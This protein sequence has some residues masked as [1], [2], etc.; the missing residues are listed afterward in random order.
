VHILELSW[1]SKYFNEDGLENVSFLDSGILGGFLI[2][3]PA[4]S[5]N[6]SGSGSYRIGA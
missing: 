4:V 3:E 5:I 6:E 1:I 2:Q